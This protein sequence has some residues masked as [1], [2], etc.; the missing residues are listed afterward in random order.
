MKIRKWFKRPTLFVLLVLLIAGQAP[1]ADDFFLYGNQGEQNITDV[2]A[3]GVGGSAG[4]QSWFTAVAY[5]TAGPNE[6]RMLAATGTQVFISSGSGESVQ[7]TQVAEVEFLMDPG[8]IRISP[9]G[10]QVA[11]G[12]GMGQPLLVFNASV[13]DGGSPDSPVNL[14][15][16]PEVKTFYETHYDFAW[17]G[18]DYLVIN[19][20]WW[21]VYGET[22]RSGISALDITDENNYTVPVCGRIMGASSGIA[23]DE[24]KNLYFGIGSGGNRTGEI[25]VFP[26]S[27]WWNGTGPTG[28]ELSYD[29][30]EGSFVIAESVLSCAYLGFDGE[31]NLHVGGGQY[32]QANPAEV[33]YAALINHKLLE[34]ARAHILDPE[35]NAFEALDE[36]RGSLYREFAP[37]VCM[38]DTATG[39]FANGSDLTVMWNGTNGT[40]TPGGGTYSEDPD[41]DLWDSGVTPILTTYHVDE[42]RDGDGDGYIDIADYSPNTADSNN[43]DSDGDGYGN[44]IDADF[45]NDDIVNILDYNELLGKLGQTDAN[46]DMN[47]DNLVNMLDYTLLL[48]KMGQTTPYYNY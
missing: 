2:A 47:G 19:G 27:T 5:F 7:W 41:W 32:V 15:D 1:A 31:G 22:S 39:V 16:S 8:F 43:I 28:Q 38:N 25:K 4:A 36:S 24:D 42:Q 45:N 14:Y 9:S 6:G 13:L 26:A 3:P 40:C 11:L 48:Y 21:V 29:D 33:G 34:D 23:V 37:D 35:N 30:T 20:G 18:E 12:L 17:V 10:R 44:I 46:I